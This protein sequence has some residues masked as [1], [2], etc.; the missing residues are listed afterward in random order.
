M[1]SAP[2]HASSLAS[3]PE[4]YLDENAGTRSV[5]RHLE[6]LGYTVFTPARLYGSDEAALGAL[7]TD[8]LPKVGQKGWAIIGRDAKIYERPAELA[9][10]LQARVQVFL[11]PGQARVD[12]LISLVDCCL[13]GICAITAQ[14]NPGTWRL[15]RSGVVP[16]E[17]PKTQK[18]RRR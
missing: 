16:Y 3:P 14:R 10:Y 13:A 12:E 17:V 4:F 8:W 1:M 9:A 5:R 11:L 7:D 18:R 15:T 2:P 6:Q